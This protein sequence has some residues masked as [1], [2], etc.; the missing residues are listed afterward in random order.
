MLLLILRRQDNL[1][2]PGRI[3]YYSWYGSI[4]LRP[5]VHVNHYALAVPDRHHDRWTQSWWRMCQPADAG[6]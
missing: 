2:V 6:L 4:L 1:H 3:D 5:Y